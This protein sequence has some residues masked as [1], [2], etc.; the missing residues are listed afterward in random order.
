MTVASQ[1]VL[2]PAAQ[3]V[4]DAF[5]KPP[6]LYDMTP[7][8]ARNVLND[9]Q[10]AAISKPPVDEEQDD[11]VESLESESSE[12]E[13]SEEM[14]TAE[15]TEFRMPDHGRVIRAAMKPLPMPWEEEAEA[16][17]DVDG[18]D[19]DDDPT[20]GGGRTRVDSEDEGESRRAHGS[21]SESS[22]RKKSR[23]CASSF[24]LRRSS[25]APWRSSR[26]RGA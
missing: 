22:I 6:F 26:S 11:E 9:A 2:E 25:I 7:A 15:T 14:G 4:A 12:S 13:S 21:R 20:P 17:S 10:S 18:D 23:A 5:S 3:Q 8:D 19:G 1:V 16:D 24:R